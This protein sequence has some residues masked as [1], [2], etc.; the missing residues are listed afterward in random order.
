MTDSQMKIINQ[1]ILNCKEYLNELILTKR[2]L[3]EFDKKTKNKYKIQKMRASLKLLIL[4][5][6]KKKCLFPKLEFAIFNNTISD[7]G[8]NTFFG[9]KD[10]FYNEYIFFIKQNKKL[11]PNFIFDDY[12][13]DL[14]FECF[15]Y[16]NK[17]HSLSETEEY[18]ETF[19]KSEILKQKNERKRKNS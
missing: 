11:F 1:E 10:S 15:K 19:I 7:K 12:D 13:D 16:K 8:T 17:N 2:Y 18:Y 3:K 14:F 5:L 4:G 6:L 9:T